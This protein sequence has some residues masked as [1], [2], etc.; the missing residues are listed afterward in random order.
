MMGRRASGARVAIG[1]ELGASGRVEG[2][3]FCGE[4]DWFRSVDVIG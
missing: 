3:A 2:V 1:G 4:L